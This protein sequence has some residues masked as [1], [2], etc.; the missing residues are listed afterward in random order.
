M[1]GHADATADVLVIGAGPAGLISARVAA[2]AG[3]RVVV[4]DVDGPE[5]TPRGAALLTPAAVATATRL[6]LHEALIAGHRVRQVRV[7]TRADSTSTTWPSHP[8]LPDHGIVVDR[9]AFDVT[10]GRLAVEAGADIWFEHE[11]IAPVV[12]RGFVRGAQLTTAS[13]DRLQARAEYVVVADG[14]NSRF[15][16]ALGSFRDPTVP[17]AVAHHAEY[18]SAIHDATEVEIVVGLRDRAG[19]PITGYAWMFPTGRGTVDLGVLLMSTSPSFRV[20]NPA[21]VLDWFVDAYGDRWHLDGGEP[22][23]TGGGRIPLGRSVGPAAGPTWLLV[24]DAAGAADPW[25]GAG[26]RAALLSGSIAG[27]VLVEALGPASATSLQRYPKLLDEHFE[28]SYGVGR[29][30]DRIVGHP[31]ISRLA[32]VRAAR[33][34]T[35][36]NSF[37]RLATGALRPGHLGPAELTFRVARALGA[38]LPGV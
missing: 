18:E 29:L 11:A 28:P 35:V 38:V 2:A 25:S 4:V 14:A 10:V 13:G 20:L 17:Y 5:R 26:L 8:A 21:H 3:R 32:T 12:E 15:G 6:G 31:A 23:M 22:T 16:R 33:S 7:S 30:A 24:G 27:D 1:T 9:Q 19:T 36:A 37:L 34:R